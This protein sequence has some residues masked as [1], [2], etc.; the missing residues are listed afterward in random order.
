MSQRTDSSR[1]APGKSCIVSYKTI[2][3]FP[4]RERWKTAF[5]VEFLS[6][7][8]ELQVAEDWSN[9]DRV[10]FQLGDAGVSRP[11]CP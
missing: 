4:K 3:I 2:T 1:G 7:N 8:P 11:S 10:R 9:E 6:Q 5:I